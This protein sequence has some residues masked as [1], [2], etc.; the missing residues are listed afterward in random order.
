VLWQ[1]STRTRYLRKYHLKATGTT[2][3]PRH[4]PSTHQT[5][6]PELH[7]RRKS[8]LMLPMTATKTIV[9]PLTPG[10]SSRQAC[11]NPYGLWLTTTSYR[12]PAGFQKAALQAFSDD[13]SI[14]GFQD[15][16]FV[17]GSPI[18]ALEILTGLPATCTNSP[19]IDDLWTIL[20]RADWT[21][22]IVGTS[23]ETKT[24]VSGHDF[25]VMT[26]TTGT[27]GSKM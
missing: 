8:A 23:S 27:D 20:C 2:Y 14:L 1:R 12:W 18:I 6:Q 7:T 26:T 15:G 21:P 10:V 19:S 17:A 11:S 22:V 5:V 16:K 4:S 13:D 25:A 3:R 24:L 9:I